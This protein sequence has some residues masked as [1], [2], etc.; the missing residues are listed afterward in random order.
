MIAG[1]PWTAWILLIASVGLGL[2]IELVFYF[3]HRAADRRSTR[4]P[5]E[6]R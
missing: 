4:T 6:G 5:D 2:A 3:N 1:L